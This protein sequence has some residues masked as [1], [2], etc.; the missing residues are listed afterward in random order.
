M[1]DDNY[2]QKECIAYS[3]STIASQW[4]RRSPM[5]W[6]L[7]SRANISC[8]N[9]LCIFSS[10]KLGL[11]WYTNYDIE[12]I[13]AAGKQYGHAYGIDENSLWRMDTEE[14]LLLHDHTYL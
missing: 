13:L 9:I 4:N 8:P 12:Y 2:G 1:S 14:P 3:T 10:L 6:V 5:K 11:V 7:E